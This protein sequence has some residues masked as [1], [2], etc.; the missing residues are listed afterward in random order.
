MKIQPTPLYAQD[1]AGDPF[2]VIGW[3]DDVR[4]GA[5]PMIVP[6]GKPGRVAISYADLIYSVE[7]I[8]AIVRPRPADA[9]TEVIRMDRIGPNGYYQ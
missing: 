7:P 6:L 2:L 3:D 1:A 8:Q 9:E 4:S 5:F